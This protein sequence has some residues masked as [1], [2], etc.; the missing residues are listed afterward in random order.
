MCY[1]RH[2]DG[3][4]KK[5]PFS[6]Q[7]PFKAGQISEISEQLVDGLFFSRNNKLLTLLNALLL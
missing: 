6:R 2:L 4:P 3:I 1:L 7:L 5:W